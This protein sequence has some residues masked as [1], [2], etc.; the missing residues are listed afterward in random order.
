VLQRQ[1][2]FS[3]GVPIFRA[4]PVLINFDELQIPDYETGIS[5]DAYAVNKLIKEGRPAGLVIQKKVF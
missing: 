5:C 2:S 1:T 4:E 3:Q